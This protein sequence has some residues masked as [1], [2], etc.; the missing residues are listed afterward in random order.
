MLEEPS[1]NGL[2]GKLWPAHVKPKPDELLSSWLVRLATAHSL[3]LH[4]FCALAWSRRKQI[5]NRDIDK[6]ADGTILSVLVEKTATP[7]RRVALTTLAAYEGY[8]YERHNPYGNTKWIMPVGIYHRTRRAYGLQFCSRCLSE[9]QEPYYRRSWRLAF[10]TLCETHH[11]S[12]IDR[13]PHCHSP[14][15]FHRSEMGDRRKWLADSITLCHACRY[16][17]RKA[18]VQDV[19]QPFGRRVLEFQKL[20]TKAM[21]SGWIR[22]SERSAI[23]SHF[24]FTVLHQL[25][26]VCATPRRATS[27]REEV[28]NTLGIKDNVPTLM[29][30]CRDI[31]R[32]GINE[33]RTLLGMADYLL[34]EWPHRFIRLCQ[35]HRV[36]SS[37]L[38]RELNPAPFWF[39]SV[40]HDHLCRTSYQPSHQE[41]IS[42]IAHL[43]GKG[44]RV[45]KKS[46]SRFLG[47]NNDVFRKRKSDI[48]F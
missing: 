47:T 5:W 1:E 34:G 3:K 17:F 7:P 6:C 12:L 42:A 29:K 15:N 46:V 36:W 19:Q 10:V 22:V 41:I 21:L 2:S 9:D 32:M 14:C 4:T 44:F 8:L 16:D 43:N 18:P 35:S 45:S 11:V 39:W 30:E 40:I 26:K 48:W 31:E 13:C 20:L 38:L 33:R 24:Y 37:T 27:L 25:M 28:R 23:D